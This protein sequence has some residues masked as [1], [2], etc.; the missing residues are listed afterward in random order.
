VK[1]KLWLTSGLGRIILS[2]IIGGGE[3]NL[4]HLGLMDIFFR[5]SSGEWLANDFL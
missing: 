2:P 4:L 3:R 1:N 5:A